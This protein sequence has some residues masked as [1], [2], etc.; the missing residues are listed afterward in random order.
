MG[1]VLTGEFVEAGADHYITVGAKYFDHKDFRDIFE[2]KWRLEALYSL[3]DGKELTEKAIEKA[4]TAGYGNTL[5]ILRGTDEL[6]WLKDLSYY[7]GSVDMWRHLEKIRGDDVKLMFV[8]MG[9]S[10]PANPAHERVLYET[11]TP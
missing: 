10:N 5:R 9:K 11:A 6:P 4:R 7:N 3:E 1:Q 8:L 2:L